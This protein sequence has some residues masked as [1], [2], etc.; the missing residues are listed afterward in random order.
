MMIAVSA[1]LCVNAFF[2]KKVLT[3][4][5]QEYALQGEKRSSAVHRV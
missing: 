5:S 3:L 2:S 1:S 4:D